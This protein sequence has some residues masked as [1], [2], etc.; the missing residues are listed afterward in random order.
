MSKQELLNAIEP[1]ARAE[2]EQGLAYPEESAGRV[3]Q[4]QFVALPEFWQVG[5][6]IDHLRSAQEL[7]EDFYEIMVVDPRFRPVGTVMISRILQQQRH[8]LLKEPDG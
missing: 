8:V 7:P 3:M 1:E 4:T 2:L 5:H 6:V